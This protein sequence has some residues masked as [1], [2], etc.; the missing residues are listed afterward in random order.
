MMFATNDQLQLLQRA[1]K[2]Y[3]DGTLRVVRKPFTQLWSIHAFQPKG[4]TMKQVPLLFVMMP[5][6]RKQDFIAVSISI[7]YYSLYE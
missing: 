7:I 6:W 4:E 1:R 3:L 5:C 2:W